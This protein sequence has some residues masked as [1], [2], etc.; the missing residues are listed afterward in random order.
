MYR[1]TLWK[2]STTN[3]KENRAP[4]WHEAKN[5]MSLQTWQEGKIIEDGGCQETDSKI[6]WAAGSSTKYCSLSE[7]VSHILRC[8]G[9]RWLDGNSFL[10]QKT[11]SKP[12]GYGLMGQQGRASIHPLYMPLFHHGRVGSWTQ[13]QRTSHERWGTPWAG[14]LSIAGLTQRQKPFTHTSNLE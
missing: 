12:Y 4:K 11:T 7:W 14:H 2:P 8:Y 3:R 5:R 9:V 6:K 10:T 13:S 1:G